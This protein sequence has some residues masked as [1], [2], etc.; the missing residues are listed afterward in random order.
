MTFLL[1]HSF[2]TDSR[3]ELELV[4][5][6]E[7][8]TQRAPLSTPVLMAALAGPLLVFFPVELDAWLSL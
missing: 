5:E 1:S 8:L 7:V 6:L 4:Q 2:V 3:Q